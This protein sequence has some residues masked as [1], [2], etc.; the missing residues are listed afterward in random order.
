MVRDVS[1]LIENRWSQM[2]SQ[3][4]LGPSRRTIEDSRVD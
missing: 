1:R 3:R 2:V 4:F